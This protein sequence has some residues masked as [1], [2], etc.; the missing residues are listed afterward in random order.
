MRVMILKRMVSQ[1]ASPPHLLKHFQAAAFFTGNVKDTPRSG[2]E[3]RRFQF[4]ES[5]K[6]LNG[7]NLFT[8]LPFL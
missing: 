4:L 2:D 5:G 3:S 6:S 1:K 7:Q 8:E